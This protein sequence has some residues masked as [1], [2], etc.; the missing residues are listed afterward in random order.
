MF[1]KR[2]NRNYKYLII[3][4]I[5]LQVFTFYP[6]ES[7]VVSEWQIKVVDEKG[8][9]IPDKEVFQSWNHYFL[10]S[11]YGHREIRRTNSEGIVVFPQ[12]NV[13]ASI[14]LRTLAIYGD[15]I[16]FINPHASSGPHSH[17]FSGR[18]KNSL[19]YSEKNGF[20]GNVLVEKD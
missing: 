4:G 1:Y 19:Y 3:L 6:F 2:L 5:L 20:S 16:G 14:P 13:R 7:V 8:N 18:S 15:V 11:E 12:R 17:V 9:P 10:E